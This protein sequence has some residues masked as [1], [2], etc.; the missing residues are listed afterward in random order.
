ML[1]GDES[2]DSSGKINHILKCP[3]PLMIKIRPNSLYCY[4]L[5]PMGSGKATGSGKDEEQSP[6]S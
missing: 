2:L 1:L 5:L 3:P 4:G 6:P